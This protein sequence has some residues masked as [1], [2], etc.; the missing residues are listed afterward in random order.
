LQDADTPTSEA[1]LAT[2][3]A[4]GS[5]GYVAPGQEGGAPKRME[6]VVVARARTKRSFL[7][8]AAQLIKVGLDWCVGVDKSSLHWFGESRF[9]I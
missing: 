7:D 1:S 9:R 2:H 6:W 5:D 8:M 3:A 4:D